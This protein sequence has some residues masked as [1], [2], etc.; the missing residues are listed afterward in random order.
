MR[1]LVELHGH[2]DTVKYSDGS[3]FISFKKHGIPSS[4][5]KVKMVLRIYVASITFWSVSL[6]AGS[7]HC[8]AK[9]SIAKHSIFYFLLILCGV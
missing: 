3:P 9:M 1:S 7:P 2:V 4:I 6:T 8:W 5:I